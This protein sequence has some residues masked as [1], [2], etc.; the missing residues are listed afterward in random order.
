MSTEDPEPI[1]LQ[2]RAKIL[3]EL[4]NSS[5]NEIVDFNDNTGSNENDD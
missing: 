2:L 3:E 4:I 5:D 1:T